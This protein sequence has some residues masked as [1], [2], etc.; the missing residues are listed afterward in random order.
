ML[1]NC[2]GIIDRT[3]IGPIIVAL[4]KVDKNAKDI[5]LPCRIA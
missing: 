4:R 5:E 2:I 1:A 3:Y